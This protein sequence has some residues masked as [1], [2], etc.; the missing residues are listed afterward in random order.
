MDWR[1]PVISQ[2]AIITHPVKNTANPI[3]TNKSNIFFVSLTIS[4][5]DLKLSIMLPHNNA[6]NGID[7][8]LHTEAIVPTVMMM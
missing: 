2:H 8:P 7:A 1:Y 4:V 5:L 6:N 3:Y